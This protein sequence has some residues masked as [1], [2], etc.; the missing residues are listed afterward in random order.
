MER[1]AGSKADV[2]AVWGCCVIVLGALAWSLASLRAPFDSDFESDIGSGHT[3]HVDGFV[4][5]ADEHYSA[6]WSV[7]DAEFGRGN[8]FVLDA[9]GSKV[10]R[11]DDEGRYLGS[12]GQAGRGPG[13]LHRPR[14]LAVRGDTVFVGAR[15]F[16]LHAYGADGTHLLDRRIEPPSRCSRMG[17][18]DITSSRFGLL[19]M[20]TCDG[21]DARAIVRLETEAGEY[22][23]LAVDAA[24]ADNKRVIRPFRDMAVLAVHPRGFAFGHPEDECLGVHD[25]DGLRVDSICHAWIPRHEVPIPSRQDLA[26]LQSEAAQAGAELAI[27]KRYPPFDRVFWNDGG[28][29]YRTPLP[30][31]VSVSQLVAETDSGSS[32]LLEAPVLFM[33]RGAA[34]AAWPDAEGMRMAVYNADELGRRR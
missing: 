20:F 33:S 28:P 32:R 31:D 17:L 22:R 25:L 14:A 6:V 5:G 16:R 27:P 10:H 23:T 4:S 12:F 11:L 34:L 3:G 13:E 15:D 26:A 18:G 9:S 1:P 21:G 29:V 19:L 30:K 7:R 24:P 8:W 2:I